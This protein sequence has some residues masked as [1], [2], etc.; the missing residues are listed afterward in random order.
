MNGKKIAYAKD[1]EYKL[2]SPPKPLPTIEEL[3]RALDDEKFKAQLRKKAEDAI[4]FGKPFFSG[5]LLEEVVGVSQEEF[6]GRDIVFGVAL[7]VP[8]IGS[9]CRSSRG[10]VNAFLGAWRD[11][12][13]MNPGRRPTLVFHVDAKFLH[14]IQ[15]KQSPL[16]K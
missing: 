4:V 13:I 11:Y 16:P 7:P 10:D 5:D 2:E 12:L 1:I 6:L 14:Q 3:E 15:V 8:D 9:L